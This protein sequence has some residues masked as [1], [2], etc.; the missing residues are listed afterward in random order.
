MAG[1]NWDVAILS[2][3]DL[4][5]ILNYGLRAFQCEREL[6]RGYPGAGVA[7][8]MG[9]EELVVAL[10]AIADMIPGDRAKDAAYVL[11]GEALERWAA[12]AEWAVFEREQDGNTLDIQDGRK[13][14][15]WRRLVRAASGPA[16]DGREEES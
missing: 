8:G 9:D 4:V 3:D 12:S 13:S 6:D 11:I 1:A 5:D 15:E 10:W 2:A 16:A 14:R 7:A